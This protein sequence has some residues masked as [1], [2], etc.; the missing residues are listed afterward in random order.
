MAE[1]VWD[2]SYTIQNGDKIVMGFAEMVKEYW[3]QL[4]AF[5]A[6]MVVLVTMKVDID[7]LKEKVATIFTLWNNK[8]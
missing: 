8:K 2:V 1:A 3:P 7:V 6:L 5:M 4:M